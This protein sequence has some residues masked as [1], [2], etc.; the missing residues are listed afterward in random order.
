MVREAMEETRW[1]FTPTAMVGAYMWFDANKAKR[2][3]RLI[4]CGHALSQD[5]ASTLDEGILS[6]HWLSRDEIGERAAELRA[7][8]VITSLDDY[9]SGKRESGQLQN[10]NLIDPE[11]IES[12]LRSIARRL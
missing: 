6:V 1:R 4:Y 9:L 8:V 2:Y 12:S 3:L 7:P 5:E 10:P 11:H